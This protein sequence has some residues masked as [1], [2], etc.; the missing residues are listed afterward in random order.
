MNCDWATALTRFDC[1]TL[2]AVDGRVGLEIGTP[3]SLP[4]GSA[5]NIY[6]LTEGS[7]IRISDTGDTLFQLPSM[8]LDIWQ[9]SRFNGLREF[10]RSRK[11]HL[12]ERGELFALARQ[13]H[14]A[15]GF[16]TTLTGLIAVSLWVAEKL[17]EREPETDLVAEL[18]PYTVARNPSLPLKLHP[19]VKGAS[20]TLH[21]FDLQH[22]EDL[23]DVMPANAI[24][25]GGAMR[26]AGDVQN[27]PFAGTAAPL[28]IV[29]DRRD[30]ARAE[31]EIAILG[32]MTRAMSASSL[33][34]PRH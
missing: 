4:D 32:S 8:G 27:G 16:A 29:D 15:T 12:T 1:R 28:F 19:K 3:F 6:L 11:L 18:E 7:H 5:I 33:M 26:K 10:A 34:A 25:T 21:T 24:A 9:P 17:G 23:I 13:E 22:G 31:S 30:P 20:R 14:A 2:P